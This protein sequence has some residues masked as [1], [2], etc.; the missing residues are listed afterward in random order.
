VTTRVSRRESFDSA[1]ESFAVAA[2]TGVIEQRFELAQMA[3]AMREMNGHARAKI[4][5]TV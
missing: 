1:M 4:V 3:E 2:R 5:V